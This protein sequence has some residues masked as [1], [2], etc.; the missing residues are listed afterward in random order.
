M[1]SFGTLVLAPGVAA[2]AAYWSRRAAIKQ[3]DVA[4]LAVRTEALIAAQL[5]ARAR[6]DRERDSMR[7][8]IDLATEPD[9]ERRKAGANILIQMSQS[10]ELDDLDRERLKGILKDLIPAPTE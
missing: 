8:A 7:H 1:L 10:N 6:E 3:A 5:A 2:V 9:Q 4:E